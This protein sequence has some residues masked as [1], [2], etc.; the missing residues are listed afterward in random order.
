MLNIY[1]QHKHS[2]GSYLSTEELHEGQN[3]KIREFRSLKE[4]PIEEDREHTN[5]LFSA[6][7][8]I[9]EHHSDDAGRWQDDGGKCA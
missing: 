8:L 2:R 4:I 1:N 5:T 3:N 6:S 7:V 9:P